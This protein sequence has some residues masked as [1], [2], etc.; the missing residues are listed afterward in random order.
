MKHVAHY[1]KS[2]FRIYRYLTNQKCKI[3]QLTVVL[4]LLT[5]E[6][7]NLLFSFPMESIEILKCGHQT[8][9]WNLCSVVFS[10]HQSPELRNFWVQVLLFSRWLNCRDATS[11][12]LTWDFTTHDNYQSCDHSILYWNLTIIFL[13]PKVVMDKR[14]KSSTITKSFSN[15]LEV[16]TLMYVLAKCV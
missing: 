14:C 16:W 4:S 7:P 12:D 1:W 10:R 3:V 5:T 15:L 8:P 11:Q 9:T 6:I 2:P 13:S